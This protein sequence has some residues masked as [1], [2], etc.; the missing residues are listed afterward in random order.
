MIRAGHKRS[1]RVRETR[2]P[3]T[4]RAPPVRPSTVRGRRAGRRRPPSPRSIPPARTSLTVTFRPGEEGR[5]PPCGVQAVVADGPHGGTGGARHVG[6]GDRY[7]V[8]VDARHDRPGR[9]RPPVLGGR[10]ARTG[11]VPRI[12][13]RDGTR[14]ADGGSKMPPSGQKA[15]EVPPP[16]AGPAAA[17]GATAAP[18]TY[19]WTQRTCPRRASAVRRLDRALVTQGPMP[20]A[21]QFTVRRQPGPL[22]AYGRVSRVSRPSPPTSPAASTGTP[23]PS[24]VTRT[25][26][27]GVRVTSTQPP[28]PASTPFTDQP[29]TSNNMWCRPRTPVEPTYIPGRFRMASR[30]SSA[31]T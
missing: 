23:G 12:R 20:K 5:T 18:R 31:A 22:P 10:P 21:L 26:P 3:P 16:V 19:S 2:R 25:P 27:S 29:T 11:D 13:Q 14:R 17:G 30:P 4:V 9:F 6:G 24:S 15:M 1:P 8:E 28:P 7:A